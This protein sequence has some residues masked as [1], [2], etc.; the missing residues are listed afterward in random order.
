MRTSLF[1]PILKQNAGTSAIAI[2]ALV[3]A[4]LA[5]GGSS[6]KPA[7]TEYVGAWTG[8]DGSTLTIRADGSGDYKS[9]GTSVTNGSVEIDDSGKTLT[10]KLLG[11][12]P[13]FNIDKAPS[14]NKMTLSGVV[15]SKGGSSSDTKSDT[16]SKK[17]S[18][19]SDDIPSDSD[20]QDLARTTVLDFN[21]AIQS[22][23]FNDF[24][25]TLSKPFQKEASADKLEG[26]FNE[27]I[28]AKL[29]FREVRNLD[30]KFTAEPE[31]VKQAGYDMLQLKGQYATTPRKTNFE[32]KYINEDG[33]WK[34]S[35]ININT[36]DQ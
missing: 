20:L 15:Y 19:S 24:H 32:L 7:P 4:A 34:L 31:I 28:K 18:N 14:G 9:G 12:G 36:K 33:E 26:V 8:A 22:G 35:S 13:S 10:I 29:D 21:D 16:T 1:K 27:F 5:C 11:M 23:D 25:A 3:I 17:S 2:V 30:A 6:G